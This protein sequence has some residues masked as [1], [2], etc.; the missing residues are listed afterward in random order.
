MPDPRVP[1]ETD[2]DDLPSRTEIR[3]AGRRLAPWVRATPVLDVDAADLGISG[4]SVPLVLKLELVQHAG[5]FKARGA[6]LQL[7]APD[8]PDAGVAAAS[9]GNYGV[10]VAYV[11][12]RLG[13]P[14][15]V[16][17]PDSTAPAK[18]DRL[19]ALG[20]KVEV[21]PGFYADALEASHRHADTTGARLVHAYDQ[22]E[23]ILGSGS[24][25]CELD[26]QVAATGGVDRLVVAVGG[27][28][29]IGGIATWQRSAVRITGVETAGCR[30]LDAALRAG[31]PVDVD[32]SGIAADALGARRV[33]ALGFEAARRWVDEVIVVDDAD[34]V[35]AQRRLWSALR[36]ATEPAGAAAFAALTTGALAVGPDE[37]VAVVVCGANV[38]PA[39]LDAR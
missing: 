23:M 30:S 26:E 21:I 3:A 5:S 18:L 2:V 15:T 35:D 22:V 13:V 10:A 31:E 17:V 9:G 39:T 34:V 1:D 12:Q 14:A 4:I 28:G 20:A 38:D 37:R 8:L 24:L 7:L 16:F 32:V 11:A 6:H 27:A 29:L 36:L 33:G 19:Q 25:A